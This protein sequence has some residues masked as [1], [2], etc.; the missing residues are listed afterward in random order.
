MIRENLGFDLQKVTRQSLASL[1]EIDKYYL[2]FVVSRLFDRMAKNN[3]FFYVDDLEL[4]D[5]VSVMLRHHMIARKLKSHIITLN[6]ATEA[7]PY[8]IPFENCIL[9]IDIQPKTSELYVKSLAPL[10]DACSK[11]GIPLII[12]GCKSYN[13]DFL[14]SFIRFD[15]YDCIFSEHELKQI[16]NLLNIK[17]DRDLYQLTSG[18]PTLL[19]TWVLSCDGDISCRGSDLYQRTLLKTLNW[20]MR[21]SLS[22]QE[23]RCRMQMLLIGQSS[24][25]TISQLSGFDVEE[26]SSPFTVVSGRSVSCAGWE[27]ILTYRLFFDDHK[28]MLYGMEGALLSILDFLYTKSEWIRLSRALSI[29]PMNDVVA[30]YVSKIPFELINNNQCSLIEKASYFERSLASSEILSLQMAEAAIAGNIESLDSLLDDYRMDE[31]QD[32]IIAGQAEMIFYAYILLTGKKADVPHRQTDDALVKKLQL[33]CDVLQLVSEGNL[34]TAYEHILLFGNKDTSSFV[35]QILQLD[36]MLLSLY[37]GDDSCLKLE[38]EYHPIIEG[39]SGS[40]LDSINLFIP[41]IN[42]CINCV[43]NQEMNSFTLERAISAAQARGY[44]LLSSWLLIFSILHNL[45]IKNLLKAY[46]QVQLL[47]STVRNCESDFIARIAILLE[48]LSCKLLEEEYSIDEQPSSQPSTPE[49]EVLDMLQACLTGK[50]ISATNNAKGS[51]A[52]IWWFVYVLEEIDKPLIQDLINIMHPS[53]VHDYKHYKIRIVNLS[54][55]IREA[56]EMNKI[57]EQL[58]KERNTLYIKVMGSVDIRSSGRE[59]REDDWTRKAAKMMLLYLAIAENHTL[60]RADLQELLWPDKDY[61]AARGNLYTALSSLKKTIGHNDELRPYIK[62]YEGYISLNSECVRVDSDTFIRVARK[63]LE[64]SSNPDQIFGMYEDLIQTYDGGLFVPVGDESG[65]FHSRRQ[66]LESLYLETLMTFAEISLRMRRPRQAVRCA[67]EILSI[68]DRRE[69]AF[70]LF[71]QGLYSMGRRAEVVTAYN[72]FSKNLINKYGIAMSPATR[73]MYT[74]MIQ[75]DP[76]PG[77]NFN[78]V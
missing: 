17:I 52:G 1:E 41:V 12:L 27:D 75:D 70:I 39:L 73:D 45:H 19:R 51:P 71:M 67:K 10:V 32:E 65:L 62:C 55:E 31:F 46:T 66:Y 26:I 53:W 6:E 18:M 21:D 78:A 29:L 28:D 14:D 35:G 49:I 22:V 25:K 54:N 47:N 20:F 59:I 50:N 76:C 43:F 16:T 34:E 61:I 63:M 2:D 15:S 60:S 3:S 37:L 9:L 8:D 5:Y 48:L 40:G 69:D 7:L 64:S 44:Y 77:V 30:H 74:E 4:K 72:I 24:F 23:R 68:D 38:S 56:N 42:D 33:H 57:E 36:L 58:N 11:K 13:Y